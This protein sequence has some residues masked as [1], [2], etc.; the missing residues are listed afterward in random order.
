MNRSEGWIAV[1]GWACCV[2]AED[3][4]SDYLDA[5][6]IDSDLDREFKE[7]LAADLLA[8]A[9]EFQSIWPIFIE[10]YRLQR[11]IDWNS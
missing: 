11:G 2:T 4:D 1:N 5:L 6:L 7:L 8:A 10:G 9:R 3:R